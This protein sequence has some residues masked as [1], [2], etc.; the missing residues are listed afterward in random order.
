M[1]PR[2]PGRTPLGVLAVLLLM[3]GLF[4]LYQW[5]ELREP[6]ATPWPERRAPGRWYSLYFSEPSG[7][8]AERLRGGPDAA[9]AAAIDRAGASVDVAAY[10]LN[11]WSLRDALLRAQRRG[12]TVRVVTESDNI[13]EPEIADLEAEGVPVIG[14]RGEALMHHKFVVIDE[15]EV[16]TGSMNFTLNGVYRN[17]NNLLRVRSSRVAED[18]RREF[19]EMFLE[20]RFGRRSL[21]DTPYPV[22]TVEGVP[23]EVYFSPDDGVQARIVELIQGARQRI[24]FMAYAF[25]SDA[26]AEAVLERAAAG[27]RVRGVVEAGQVGNLGSEVE[28]LAAGGV[29]VRLDANPRNMHHKVIIID[30]VTVIT[31]SYNF[32]RSAEERNDE[33]VLVIH[34]AEV[35]G[36]YLIEFNRLFAAALP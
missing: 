4:Y 17:N 7:P 1:M 34:D 10:H 11:L 36:Q 19:D 16:W 12:L 25:T 33:N 31:G 5:G 22:V 18:Y 27:V 20:D 8:A 2:A 13:L 30:G 6:P 26:L 23:L 21:R 15:M 29:E 24:E 28:R 3:A 14:D 35:A 9:L 32:S